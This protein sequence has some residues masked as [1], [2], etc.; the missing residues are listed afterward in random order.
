M[1][2]LAL[3]SLGLVHFLPYLRPLGKKNRLADAGC[4]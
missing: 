1:S 2:S 4:F 3:W